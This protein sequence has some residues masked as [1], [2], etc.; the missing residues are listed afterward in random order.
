MIRRGF[1]NGVPQILA[2]ADADIIPQ[3]PITT[4]KIGMKGSCHICAPGLFANLLKSGILTAKVE[5]DPVT[6]VIELSQ[7]QTRALPETVDGASKKSLLPARVAIQATI[8]I[9]TG[10]M[11]IAF[12]MNIGCSLC[13]G[14]NKNGNWTR[15]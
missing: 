2:E 6:A 4:L 13:I 14:I 7:S 15:W 3:A 10:G 1:H 9:A 8:P 11:T 5:Y 12:A